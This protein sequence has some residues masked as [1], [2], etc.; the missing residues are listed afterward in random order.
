MSGRVEQR[1]KETRARIVQAALD[2]F[3]EKGVEETTVAEIS[4]AADIGKGTFFT[5]FRTKE[6][7]FADIGSLMFDMMSAGAAASACAGGG[8][9]EQLAQVL[10]PGI[11]WHQQHPRLSRLSMTVMMR[12]PSAIDADAA[13]I[14]ALEAL[15]AEVVTQGQA[16]G[17]F[18]AEVDPQAA[19]CAL[20]G[21]YF[22]ALH[23]WHRQGAQGSLVEAF[24]RGLEVLLRGL[25]R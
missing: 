14:S 24:R 18:R 8:P 11:E 3:A 20:V 10:L 16:S 1:K 23:R 22:I 17:A 5:Y 12:A 25:A 21:L 2:L 6:E 9:A 13:N 19:G 4:E 15:L 7:V